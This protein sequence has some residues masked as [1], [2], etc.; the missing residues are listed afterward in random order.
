MTWGRGW[1]HWAKGHLVYMAITGCL[2][3]L[4][5]FVALVAKVSVDQVKQNQLDNRN[6]SSQLVI[7]GKFSELPECQYPGEGG[8]LAGDLKL[9]IQQSRENKEAL[10]CALDILRG[11]NTNPD[12]QRL[13]EQAG[14]RLDRENQ[15]QST[16]R[17]S[18]AAPA[19]SGGGGGNGNGGNGGATQGLVP[20]LLDVPA[21]NL[22]RCIAG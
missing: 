16:S 5:A 7:G 14:Q 3:A 9:A 20:C 17:S 12:C 8:S 6:C 15:S 11:E 4:V 18:Q 13:L 10:R 19:P 22:T 1:V 2:F 21:T